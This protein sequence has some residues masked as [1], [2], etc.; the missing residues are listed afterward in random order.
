MNRW[1]IPLL[2]PTKQTWLQLDNE[3]LFVCV[4][5][6]I[7]YKWWNIMDTVKSC[8]L[9]FGSSTRMPLLT[10]SNEVW[11]SNTVVMVCEMAVE[12]ASPTYFSSSLLIPPGPVARPFC[13]DLTTLSTSSDVTGWIS[14]IFELLFKLMP[15]S[16]RL[17]LISAHVLACCVMYTQRWRVGGGSND[18]H[19]SE[20]HLAVITLVDVISLASLIWH[21]SFF[22]SALIWVQSMLW[23]ATTV[24]SA[25]LTVWQLWGH[26]WDVSLHCSLSCLQ[27]LRQL[28]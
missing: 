5:F 4:C 12:M 22:L 2:M 27:S 3:Q 9:S 25:M 13:C 19:G 15:E 10:A 6:H 8:F 16:I 21:R 17:A 20:H 23:Y 1:C 7:S 24:S 14:G 26:M 18:V 11:V 28:L